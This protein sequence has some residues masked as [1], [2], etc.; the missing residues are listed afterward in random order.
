MK[1]LALKVSAITATGIATMFDS[2]SSLMIFFVGT[3]SLTAFRSKKTA[4]AFA[5]HLIE[6]SKSQGRTT[7][8]QIT[9]RDDMPLM[10]DI[11]FHLHFDL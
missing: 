4:S 8:V 7:D 3:T 9:S 5:H 1:V 11:Q 2:L 6:K 10:Q